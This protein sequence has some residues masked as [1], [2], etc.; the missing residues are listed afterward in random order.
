MKGFRVFLACL[1][2]G[3]AVIAAV[4][5]VSQSIEQGLRSNA[6]VLL[7]G[8]VDLRLTHKPAEQAQ[9]DWLQQNSDGLSSVAIMRAMAVRADG[10]DRRLIELKA[11]D[12]AYP[13]FGGLELK[14]GRSLDQAFEKTDG[15]WGVV[16]APSLLERLKMDVGDR[17]RIGLAT[18]RISD[19]IQLEPD[20]STQAFELGPRVIVP[21]GL[22]PETDL[23]K[24]GSMIRYHYRL[25]IPAEIPAAQWQEQLNTQFPAAGWRVRTLDNAA[26]NIQNFVDKVQIFL[27]LIGLTALLVGGVGVGNAASAYLATRTNTIATLKCLGGTVKTCLWH[28]SGPADGI[29]TA[30]IA[31]WGGNRSRRSDC[32]I[33]NF[34][35]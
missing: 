29:G 26:P 25:D 15:Q 22:L 16:V 4:G 27:T 5:A 35:G 8:E 21:A 12:N 14:S 6:R 33:P 13:L 31:G 19:V 34:G 3:V 28:L 32:L 2:L 18:V 20:R 17:F 23:V 11:V 9:L 24:P 30:G 1:A 10:Q 7:G